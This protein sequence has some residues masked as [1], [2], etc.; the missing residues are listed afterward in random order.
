VKEVPAE[1]MPTMEDPSATTKDAEMK[2]EGKDAT[3]EAKAM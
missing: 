3:P 1:G 2:D